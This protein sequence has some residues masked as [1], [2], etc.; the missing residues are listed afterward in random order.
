MEQPRN[1]REEWTLALQGEEIFVHPQDHDDLHLR[2]HI[3]RVAEEKQ[4]GEKADLNAVDAMLNH[5]EEH[6]EQKAQKI[7]QQAMAQELVRNIAQDP[8]ALQQVLAGQ[9]GA[10][11]PAQPGQPAAPKP[12]ANRGADTQQPGLELMGEPL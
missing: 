7:M 11:N 1:P 8:A 2:D 3:R 10:G 4:R 5:I 9:M 12:K 6:Q